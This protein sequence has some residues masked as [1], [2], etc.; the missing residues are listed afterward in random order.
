MKLI[1][2]KEKVLQRYREQGLVTETISGKELAASAERIWHK[3]ND[4]LYLTQKNK[5]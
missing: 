2:E 4:Y 1:S 5:V 3:L